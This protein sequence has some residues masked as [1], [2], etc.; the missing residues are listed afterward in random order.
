MGAEGDVV[1]KNLHGLKNKR[2]NFIEKQSFKDV[3]MDLVS[4]ATLF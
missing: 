1:I 4:R 3:A 2:D